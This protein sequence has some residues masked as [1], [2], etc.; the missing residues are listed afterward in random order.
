LGRGEKMAAKKLIIC[1]WLLFFA[2]I[3]FSQNTYILSG[4]QSKLGQRFSAKLESEPV[5]LLQKGV[6]TK[7][8]GGKG[9]FW[10]NKKEGYRIKNIYKFWNSKDAINKTLEAG[11]YTVY[12]NLPKNERHQS[13]SVYLKPVSSLTGTE[14]SGSANSR[15]SRQSR[16]KEENEEFQ[17]E[18]DWES[19]ETGSG[20]WDF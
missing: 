4:T 6:I 15:D 2:Q 10:I 16:A 8:T 5:V 3:S 11:T 19:E 12:P 7:V 17:K 13:V 1:I 20:G 9:G 14:D 18:L